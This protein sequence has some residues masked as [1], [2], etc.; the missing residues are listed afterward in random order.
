MSRRELLLESFE[1]RILCDATA[2]APKQD[3]AVASTA[4]AVSVEPETAPPNAS[5]S[6]TNAGQTAGEDPAADSTAEPA[7][8]PVSIDLSEE[9]LSATDAG[10]NPAATRSEI[11]FVDTSVPSYQA[12]VAGLSPEAEV[13]FLR[14]DQ[15]GLQ[16]MAQALA[17]RTGIDAIHVISHGSQASLTIGSATLTTENMQ[18]QYASIL[19]TI[20]ESLTEGGDLLVYGCNFGK[21][22]E[23]LEAARIL[24]ELTGADVASSTNNT[25]SASLGGDWVLEE[26][27]GPISAGV[28]VSDAAQQQWSGLL[29]PPPV[30]FFYV[31]MPEQAMLASMQAINGSVSGTTGMDSI[32]VITATENNTIIYYDHWE[33]GY[34]DVLGV[35]TQTSGTARTQIWGDGD[36]TNGSTPGDPTDAPIRA[37]QIIT[38]RN[39]IPLPRVATDTFFDGGDKIGSTR[40]VSISRAQIPL[41][42]GSVISSAV[43]VRDTRYFGTSYTAPVGFNTPR[44]AGVGTLFSDNFL[45]VM[46]SQNNTTVQIDA[47]ND[48]T[49]EQTVVLNEGQNV[50]ST[51]VVNQGGRVVADRP[52]QVNLYNGNDAASYATRSYSL[53]PNEQLT[54]DY[55]T[56]VGDTGDDVVLFV[57]N[58]NSTAIT[59]SYE[60]R[61]TSGNLASV[62]AGATRFFT[63]PGNT[64]TRLYTAGGEVF[65]A[66]GAHDTAGDGSTRDWGFSLQPTASLSQFAV[67]GLGVGN[68]TIPPSGSATNA[69]PIWVTPLAATTV[70]VDNDGDPTTGL[71][72]DP[73][74]NTRYDQSFSLARLQSQRVYDTTGGDND[75][76]GMRLFTNDGTLISTAWGEDTVAPTGLPGFDAGTTVPALPVPEFFKFVDFAP[77]GD[78]NGDGYFNSGDTLRY[79][80]RIRN[81]GTELINNAVAT[82]ALPTSQ[83]T[84]VAGSTRIDQ[85]SGSVVVPDGGTTAFPLDESGYT[86]SNL[87]AGSTTTLT[88]DVTVNNG[89]PAGTDTLYNI[90]R[91]EYGVF[92]IPAVNTAP[93]RGTVEGTVYVDVNND[94]DQD[95]GELGIAGVTLT[96]TGTDAL[97]AAVSRTVTTDA[98]GRYIFTNL[99]PSNA[100]GYTVTQTQ[101]AGYLD[102]LEARGG[103]VIAGS[104]GGA[105]A[106]STVVVLPGELDR[107]NN[108]GELGGS[109]SGFVYGD[110]SNFGV[111]DAFE[112][113]IGGVTVTLTGTDIAGNAVSV[114]TTTAVGTGAYSFTGLR[115]SNAAGYTITETQPSGYTDGADTIGTPGGTAG[116]DVFSA[117]VLASGVS[118]TNN[119]FGESP[120]FGLTK[121]LQTTSVAGTTGS[122]LAIGETA[123]FRLVT[124]V[125]AGS[126]TN[127][128]IQDA[129]PAGFQFVN[130]SAVVSLVSSAGQLTSSTLSGAGLA[131]TSVGTPTFLMPDSAVSNSST[132]NV[133]TYVSGTDVFFKLGNLTNTD[134]TA[135]VES[136]VIEF[137]AI[138]VNEAANQ[139]ATSLANTFSV[140]FD[141]DGVGAPDAHGGSSNTVTSTVVE[142]VLGVTK[143][144]VV[145]GTDAGDAVQ[146]TIT[147]TNA[148]ANNATAYD[149]NVLDALDTDI[150]LNNVTLGSGIVVSGAAVSA[151]TSTTS[152]LNLVLTSLAAG[153]SVTITLNG[154]VA[155]SAPVGST[156]TNSTNVS[157]TSTPGANTNERTGSGGINDYAGSAS[158]ADFV[159]AR[160]TVDKLTP[161]DTTYSVG[162]TVTYDI[163]VTLPEG[164]TQGLAITDNLPAGLDFVSVAVQTAAGGVLANAFNGT[165]PAPVTSNVGNSYT[166]T[167]GNTTT[168]N[169]NVGTNNSFLVRVTARVANVA[170]NQN[171]VTLTNTATLAYTD[172]TNGASTVN[173]LTP[174]VDITVVEP[175]LTLDKATIGTTTGLDAGDTV[176]YSITITNTGTATAHEVLLSDALPAGLLVTAIDSTT[177][178]AG[179]SIDTATAGVGTGTLTGEYTIPVGESITIIYTATLQSSVTPNTNYLNTATVTYSSVDGTALG[180]G[181]AT[182]ERNGSGG[183]NDYVLTDTAQVSTGG[184]L[185]VAKGVDN[186]T[187]SI[188][189]VLTYTVTLTL[190][191]GTT[192]GIVVT[193]TLPASGDLQFVAGSAAVSFG[194]AGSSISG[195][196]VPVITGAN[197]NILTFTLGSAVVPA[198]AGANTVVLTYQVLVR[199]VASNQAGDVEANNAHVVAT[200]L[201]TPPDSTTSVTLREPNVTFTKSADVTTNIDAGDVITYTVT[202]TNPGG[203]NASTAFDA[204]LVDTLPA[205][206]LITGI[207]STT[208]ADGATEDSAATI[209][210]GGAGLTGQYDIP[211][212]ATVTIVYTATVQ[213][214]FPPNG[215]ITNNAVLTW[216]STNGGNSTAPDANERYGAAGS[217]FGD[218]S[219]N[220]YRRTTDVTS[221][222]YGPTFSKVLFATSEA[223]TTGNDLT[224][225]ETATYGLLITLPEGTTPDLSVIDRLPTGLQYLSYSIVTTAAASNGILTADFAGTVPSPT[226]TGGAANGDDVTFTFGSIAVTGDNN[227]A[228]N[229]FLI[230]VNARVLDEASN[231]GTN[232]PGRTS[233]VNDATL[234]IPSDPNPLIT[235]NTV[236][237]TVAE[238]RLAITKAANDATPDVGQTLTYTLTITHTATSTADAFDILV[239][240]AIPT[241]L[242]LATGSIVVSGATVTANNSTATN[243]SLD[244]DGLA[245]GGTVTITFNATVA[246]DAALANQT[247]SNNA[248]IYWDTLA[249]DE[250]SNAVLDNAPDGT[251]DRDLGATNGYTEAATPTPNEDSQDTEDVVVNAISNTIS[252]VVYQDVNA[253]GDYDAGTDALLDGV[254]VELLGFDYASNP[255][256]LTATT[257][258]GAYSFTNVLPGTY[259]IVQTQPAGYVDALETTGT[260]FGGTTSAAL[261]NNT[262]TTVTVPVGPSATGAGYNFGEVLSS[263][264]AGFTYLDNNSD[265]VFS[266]ESAL[267]GIPITL[268]GTDVYGQAVSINATT[269]ANGSYSFT[270]LRPGTYTITED[271]SAVVS[272][273]Y[274]DG[275]ETLGTAGG[276]IGG[277]APKNDVFNVTLAQG[278]TGT[279]YNF[280]E[281]EKSSLSGRVFLDVDE[282]GTFGG[283]DVGV[284]G[285]TVTLTGTDDLGNAVNV[286][287]TTL[288]TGAYNFAN[289]RPGTYT[290]TETQPGG[291]FDGTDTQGT[292]GTGTTGNDV[293]SN[294]TL[295]GGVTGA[296]NNFGERFA[297]VLTK[298]I[299]STSLSSTTGNDLAV[300]EVVRYR[301][302]A[303]LPFGSFNDAQI[304]DLLP[305][306]LIFLN[307][308]TATVGFVSPTGTELTS[309]LISG[310]GLTSITSPTVVLPDTAISTN[311]TTNSDSYASGTDVYFKFG[312]L[313]NITPGVD[314]GTV[315]IEFNARVVNELSNQAGTTLDNSF[316]S[317]IDTDGDGDFDPLLGVSNVVTSTVVEP[318]LTLGKS[319]S[320][321]TGVVA[322][323]TITYTVTFSNNGTSTA[324]DSVVTDT[325]PAYLQITGISSTVLA[326]GATADSAAAITGGGTGLTGQYDIP[327]GGSVTITYTAT[328]LATYPIGTQL[329]NSAALTWTS[330]PGGNSGTPDSG[331]RFGVSPNIVNDGSLNDY[332]QTITNGVNGLAFIPQVQKA[333]VST[334]EAGSTGSNVL[335]GEVVRYELKVE[336]FQ[337]FVAL[338]TI[339]DYLPAGMLF[340]PDGPVEVSY[341]NVATSVTGLAAGTYTNTTN[342]AFISASL[343]TDDDNFA[344]GTD[345]FFKFGNIQNNDN[346]ADREFV[347]VRFNVLVTNTAGNVDGTVL[348]NN[349]GVLADINGT[350]T[351]GFVSVDADGDGQATNSEVAN[352][353]TNTGTGTPGLSNTVNVMV[354]EPN[355]TLA[356][357][358]LT[359][360][361]SGDA[362]DAVSYDIVIR[363]TG[364]GP[365]YDLVLGDVFDAG[366][367]GLAVAISGATPAPVGTDPVA[368]SASIVGNTIL[369]SR[370]DA[371]QEVTLTVTATLAQS[372][373]PGQVIGN[374]VTLNSYSSLPGTGTA[375]GANNTTGSTTPGASGTPTGERDGSGGVNTY[376][377]GTRTAADVVVPGGQVVK[378]LFATSEAATTDPL[379]AI[380]EQVTYALRVTLPE[381]TT[382]GL[383]LIDNIPAGMQYVSTSLVTTVVGS[384]GLLTADFAGTVP[385]P[386]VTG[387]ASSGDDAT[388]TFGSITVTGDNATGNNSFIA[389]VTMRVLDEAGNSGI[390]PPGQTTL[391]NVATLNI[392]SNP[393]VNTPPVDVTVVEPRLQISKVVDDAAVDLGQTLNYTLTIQHTGASTA[394]A[395]DLLVREALPAG[396]TLIPASINVTSTS[397]NVA[398]TANASTTTSI[399]LDL[400]S[401]ALGDVVTITYSATVGTSPALTGTDIDNN[402][403]LYW[404]TTAADE[405]NAILTNT[406]DGTGDRDFGATDGYVENPSPSPDD[407][408]QDTERVTVNSNL[409]SGFVYIDADGNGVFGVENG[410]DGVTITLTG[411]DLNGNPVNQSVLTGGDGSFIFT[412]L[413]AGTYTLTQ[414]Q[415]ANLTDALENVGTLFGGTEFDTFGSNVIS[416]I[417][418]P[419]GSPQSG[420]NYNF[421]EVRPSTIAGTVYIDANNDGILAGETG[422]PNIT[423]TLSGTDIYGQSVLLTT[424]TDLNGNYTFDNGGAGLRQSDATGY[425][426]TQGAVP[427]P[428]LDGKET[429]GSLSGS[430]A[431]NDAISGIVLPQNTPAT[432]YIF[433]ELPPASLSGVVYADADNDG[434]LDGG[435]NGIGGV[436]VRLTGTDDLGNLVDLQDITDGTGAY[437]FANLRPGTYTLTET[438]PGAY[439]DG[440]ETVG[441]QASGT[442]DN[443]QNSNTISAITLLT[444]VDGAANNFAELAPASLSGSVY[445]DLDNDG[446]FDAFESGVPGVT[447]TLTGNDDRGNA[448]NVTVTT[449]AAG[450]YSFANLRPSDG[451]GYTITETQ[452]ADFSDGTDT[453]GTP[454]GTANNDS[455][456]AVILAAGVNGANNNFGEQPT[457]ALT[458]SLVNT[459]EAG[460]TG[461]DVTI[462]EVAT[463]RL[464]VTVPA[465]SLTNF[466]VRDLLPAGYQYVDGSARVGLVGALTSSTITA[467]LGSI[468][469]P[470]VVLADAAVSDNALTNSDSYASGT[471][472][473][474]KLGDL[475]NTDA[476]AAVEAIV[477]EFD[478]VVVNEATNVAG[479]A[480]TNS[481]SILYER[482]GLPNPDPDPNPVP[483]S[484]TTTVVTPVLTFAKNAS[485]TGAV[486]AGD[487]I[488]Y[489]LTITNPGGANSS[490]AFDALVND[491]MPADILITS[492]TSTTLVGGATTDS[493]AAITGGGT[494][495]TGQYDIPV[496]GSVTI[497]YVGTVQVSAA[498]GS[499]QI[500]NAA[501]TWTSINGNNSLTPDAGERYGAAGTLY[502]DANLNNLRRIASQTVTVGTATFG[503]QLFSTSD[504]GTSGSN[505]AIG[506]TVTYALTVTVPAGTAPSL[507]VVDTLPSGLQFVSSL[508]LTTAA[509]SNGLLTANFNGTVPAPTVTGG[510]ADGD[511]VTFNFGSIVAAAD[512]DSTNNTFLILVTA[513]VTDIAGN[514]GILPGQTTLDNTAT[515]EIPGD[516]VPPTTPPPVTV[517]V[518][519][520]VLTIDKEFNVTQA[521]A[522]DTVQVSITVGNTGTAPVYDV[523]ITDVVDLTKFGSITEVTTPGGFTF[524]NTLGTVSYSGGSIA[525][526]GSVTFVFS[527]ALLDSVNPSEVLSNTSSATG[528]SQSGVVTGERT[529]GPVQDTDTLTVPAV[530]SLTKGIS[531]PTGGAVQIGDVVTY[532]VTVTVVEGTTQNISLSD[533]LPTGMSYVAGSAVV[534]NANGM[535]VNGF[536]AGVVG[537]LLTMTATS[538]VNPG[539]VDNTS[540]TDSDTFTITYQTVVNDVAGNSSGTLLTN[541]LT[542]GGTGVPPSTPPP[543]TTTVTEP[544]LKVTKAADDGTPDL[545]QTV[546]FT[547]TIQNLAVANGATAFDILVRDALPSGLEGLT[548]IVVS[549]AVIDSNTST[550][551]LLDLK[552][553]QLA[554]GATATVEFDAVVSSAAAFAG[555]SIDNNAR[556]YWDSQ[557]GESANSV[558]TGAADGDDDRDYGATGGNEVF[559]LDTQDEQDTERLVVNGNT[560]SGV[561]YQDA[562]ASGTL[563][564]AETG[565]GVGV[566]VTISGKTFFG[567]DFTQTVTADAT[568]GIYTFSNVPRSDATGYTITEVQPVSFVDGVETAGTP[569]GGATNSALNTDD[570]TAIVVPVGANIATG[571][572]FG[573]LLPSSLA[574]SVYNDTNNDGVRQGGETGVDA[575]PVR[576]TGTDAFGQAVSID[577]TSNATGD[578]IFDNGGTGLRPGT[579]TITE[580]TQPAGLLDG[581]ETAGTSLGDATA[582]NEQISSINLAQNT[583]ATDYLFGELRPVSL[584]GFV[585]ADLDGDGAKDAGE[586]GLQGVTVR[587][588][589]T[590]DLGQPVDTTVLTDATGAYSFTNLRPGTYS[591]TETQP[592]DYADGADT[593]GTGLSAPNSAGTVGADTFTGIQFLSVA[594]GNDVGTGYNFGEA[595][596]FNPTKS[597]VSTS[598]TS[599]TGSNVAIGETARFR[600]VVNVPQ[601]SLAN[602]QIQD[603]LP[604]GYAYV[605]GSARAGIVSSAGQL[606][607]TLL[608]A[609][610]T[611]INATPTVAL[612]D[613]SVSTDPA[614]N[615]DTYTS[616]TDIYFKFGTLTNSDTNGATVEGIV[617][618]FDAI[619][620][621]EAT[622]QSGSSLENSFNV[623]YD[624]DGNGTPDT[625]PTPSNTVVTTVVEPVLAIAKTIST[626]VSQVEAGDTVTYQ[627]TVQHTGASN[628]DAFDLSLSDTI[629]AELENVTLD[630]AVIGA[631]NVTSALNLTGNSLTTTGNIDLLQGQT[632]VITISGQVRDSVAPATVISN[633][634]T[635]TYTSLD[636]AVT[637]ERDGSGGVNDYTSTASAPDITTVG[638]LQVAKAADKATA[639]LGE[640]VTYTVTVTVGEGTTNNLV[641]NDTLPAGMQFVSGSA[642]IAT[643]PAGMTITGF[644]ANSVDQTLTVVNPGD[645]DNAAGLD[646]DSFTITYQAIVL[647]V[648]GNQDGTALINDLDAS[649]DNLPPDLDNQVTVTVTEPQLAV[650]KTAGVATANI[651]DTISYTLVVSHTAASTSGAF[652]VLVRDAIP[653]GFTLNLASISVTG[654]TL[655]TDS[656]T[657][658]QL[659]LK[660]TALPLASTATITF[661]VTIAADPALV[662]TDIDNNA[663]VYWDS[664]AGEGTNTVLAGGSDGDEDR[665]YGATG[666]DEV[667]NANTQ[668][669]QDTERVTINANTI[670]GFAYQDVNADGD[671]DAGT[672]AL[673]DGVQ[674]TLTGTLAAGGAPFTATA[675]S[676]AGV[677]VFNNLPAG[678]FT[679]T[680]TQPTGY[681]DGA[682]TAGTPFGG[683]VSAVLDSNTIT[684]VVIPSGSNSGTGYNFGEVLGSS[685]ASSVFDDTNND[686][687]RAGESGIQGVSVRLT[688]TDFL[689]QVVDLQGTTL[690]DGS[691]TFGSGETLRPGTYTLTELTQPAGFLDGK[692]TAGP[693]G[694]DATSVND[695]ISGIVLPQGTQATD[696]VFGELQPSSISGFVFVDGNGDGIKDPTE[697]GI[698]GV[699]I[700]LT[701]T[702][703]LGNPV[704]VSVTTGADGSY[705][706]NNLRPGAYT[707]TETQPADYIDGSEYL[708]NAGGN[709]GT[710][711]VIANIVLTP[712]TTATGYNFVEVPIPPTIPPQPPVESKPKPDPVPQP[713]PFVFAFDTF[714]NFANSTPPGPIPPGVSPIDIWGSAMLP[715][716]P[717][718]SGA[719]NPGATLV[720]ELYNANGVHIGSQTVIADSGGNWLAN[721]TSVVL[722]DAPSEVRI[723]QMNAPYSFGSGSGHN[724]RTYYAPAALNPGHFLGQT[725]M[726]GHGDEPAPLLQGL[727]LANPIAL[728]PVK[729]GGEFLAAEGVASSN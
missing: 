100:T 171:A 269:A 639:T 18:G 65:A 406:P 242:T 484:V 462:G 444:G 239:R 692:D 178:S 395:F 441:S 217:T 195:S 360:A 702:D 21:G 435:E 574:G 95:A 557:A 170:G 364:N 108:F 661:T 474:F 197:S 440:R 216:T 701:G 604:A 698:P 424:T 222:G 54:N 204:L 245:Q 19:R 102:G 311:A 608:T 161:S 69:S 213:A 238:P 554:L 681:V 243:L 35:P 690:A 158:S 375:S 489:T 722:R 325:A 398:I 224:I 254:T 668:D 123:T 505:V 338:G 294:I 402:V 467:P 84:Y 452:P 253:D 43:E 705:T 5:A 302:T 464:V 17:G 177:P 416:N 274:F 525:A 707:L 514:E 545:G 582:T 460:T 396:L 73:I 600:L 612:A 660:L 433:G 305:T 491:V 183:L 726:S 200:D 125:P 476:T 173:D 652:D 539:N 89:L 515:F 63:V 411:T 277:T 252:G 210:G 80:L 570:I 74:T 64:G 657:T 461:S 202:L 22:A 706:F 611:D 384:G 422:I 181:T 648:V 717:I 82:D 9:Q 33:N 62:A 98:Q 93:L 607:S 121:S 447:V 573:E 537:Q 201:T 309:S 393:P 568:T 371:G 699:T 376:T 144:L 151:N 457:F 212:G 728:G 677:Y 157:W 616:G 72:L 137:Q 270:G 567:E 439:F 282:N 601:G 547:L 76:S 658:S 328:V 470:T 205:N 321:N 29:A 555:A 497:T 605:N 408:A 23:G 260:T 674:I 703:D 314:S 124:T 320:P 643:N 675:T 407:L 552:L 556:I 57:Y 378:S 543:V 160:P 308:G 714:R 32:I 532:Q 456:S 520:P 530:F 392:P 469:T 694:G 154:T 499:T 99:K 247:L 613:A 519:E 52:V 585:Y 451:A 405:A 529:F 403:R 350:G 629:P 227:A 538:V 2:D 96:L 235:S 580:L 653:S 128:Q 36:P 564:G 257:V 114:T 362:G 115:Q 638:A 712:G 289:L 644:N 507:S 578:F 633:S 479:T 78:A 415:P 232:P 448:V 42:T 41:P 635:T 404:D 85:G 179:A 559:D 544:Q 625:N 361:T 438:Q 710:N 621:N 443:T 487:P 365:A 412:N 159:L 271:D 256:L 594:A 186:A 266:G 458:K 666:P 66:I 655:E 592:A 450:G 330:L 355:V 640:T 59:V 434:I 345:V 141:K 168:T 409:I 191:E 111:K 103:V 319:A 207:T 318:N 15:D 533:T 24:A 25:G 214:G 696:N 676:V 290:I 276:T 663:R 249:A 359:T 228:S 492:I 147:I 149:I 335:V 627:I 724:L 576:L 619:V 473:F 475:T 301:L 67:V 264:L 70:Y 413:A 219:L 510:V 139:A 678:T 471:D 428:Y 4:E 131:Q 326:G 549:G 315:V 50:V 478:A 729:Y 175:V 198:G 511:D 620:V 255:V 146:Y 209:T 132:A 595:P 631:T 709:L 700:Q 140:L 206:L 502:G 110:L 79:T 682:E 283:A 397:G 81:L 569:F 92:K 169:D 26:Q 680:E 664:Q 372:V 48:G 649:A 472:V 637:G 723:T 16:Q 337:G 162:E 669:A 312:T 624:R 432:G 304:Y 517:T 40:T 1:E 721:F 286:V 267:G 223:A 300:G 482:D 587:L 88:F 230:L 246:N 455:F 684:G 358:T 381:G 650:T 379:V 279:D 357:K 689:G 459:S 523:S 218:G 466:Q 536:A 622:V 148:A 341:E 540:T 449:N 659:D 713:E 718:Y 719:A 291:Y 248:R 236:T 189:E 188:G 83:V 275:K 28:A 261:G 377:G 303:T 606:T 693:T 590:D 27:T 430:T 688:G 208:L 383:V 421:G 524:N 531:S 351:P 583:A 486:G 704:D 174:N 429:A 697:L 244:L 481:F 453:I 119:N 285:V 150:L 340:L 614:A 58:P 229:S 44:P 343:T 651:G 241:G 77:G 153:S 120:S 292:P 645:A 391:G 12:L 390:N 577:G 30:Q 94:G 541:S 427:A 39:T 687:V 38:L 615:D 617:I 47:D 307:D 273:T 521:D 297:S 250:A 53:L 46:A 60:T 632:L 56:P 287:A 112:S 454:G 166:F 468:T 316:G 528:T 13:I 51:A 586:S 7:P 20:G 86:I 10:Q 647:D 105:N 356:S 463:F 418:I 581:K 442:V 211:V 333:I 280:A 352:D 190:N 483:P 599:T 373:A 281:I 329:V 233:L 163:L 126:F 431:T 331:E 284:A 14:Q 685:I 446:A 234:D 116:N 182:G 716:A 548:N 295:N 90:A 589:G 71:F 192:N 203:A 272:G 334:S 711:D 196:T 563:N 642:V 498:P 410:V 152:N 322:G 354:I 299:V 565:L 106:I 394:T 324:Y 293:F 526:G 45:Y 445:A 485:P 369:L 506:E 262:I 419:T 720:I 8:G 349:F 296:N 493:A 136:I 109:L 226:V 388:L 518:V 494:G 597:L 503:K 386:T 495:L 327:V 180:Q 374:T 571:Y 542:G 138:V 480:L 342:D 37:G 353:P 363:N 553:A 11:V 558:L 399:S 347:I 75:Q 598:S 133:D 673:L 593:L 623:L 220:D 636:G 725:I 259:S 240:D 194:T 679:L 509:G 527:V 602:F 104:G 87:L 654:A 534:S 251:P 176:Q 662:G 164:V 288:G 101:P 344:D 683:S 596:I 618:E 562:D 380:G 367:T 437:S 306:G 61:T 420:V 346:D 516:G 385:A 298:S 630:S 3:T 187:P 91:L 513:R 656:S 184:V 646:S 686:G 215:S 313:T 425:T 185:T 366:L 546:H 129:L 68:S 691:F 231:I 368:Q 336:L 130:G 670:T 477:I 695:V 572:N 672:D 488:T 665:D 237:S 142:P 323:E 634:A 501:L 221:T 389:L 550:G 401:L 609:P 193:D 135:S 667:F 107:N 199:N 504:A 512:G 628:A 400:N 584:S 155:A 225:G 708:G 417:V 727:D 118:G 156:V 508:I 566:Q 310:A 348:S 278:T 591:I 317:G 31:P 588:T 641:L 387:G 145:S 715:L 500:N 465:G 626:A 610:L 265:G 268:T 143:A 165:V 436:T 603:V 522:G 55:F 97:G 579:Y 332:R 6:E 117:I 263:S 34:E 370:L 49:F 172:G 122:N 426:I 490:M 671:Y 134:T 560:I 561:V 258:G 496:G 113:G 414:T 127:F 339:R 575:V 423:M 382:T 551:T 167:F 535:T